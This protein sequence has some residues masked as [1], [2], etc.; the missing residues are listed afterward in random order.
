M[1]TNSRTAIVTSQHPE[2][3]THLSLN[4]RH[5][6]TVR[7]RFDFPCGK[8][9]P[10]SPPQK[11]SSK[12]LTFIS[13]YITKSIPPNAVEPHY[14]SFQENRRLLVF[15]EYSKS[16]CGT[17]QKKED[18]GFSILEIRILF[19]KCL[20]LNYYWYHSKSFLYISTHAILEQPRDNQVRVT[21]K[22][23]RTQST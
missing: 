9:S 12:D 8:F 16:P 13:T 17:P 5:P 10:D 19:G 4:L 7:D 23:R 22:E 18:N 14:G 6:S 15:N 1:A 3:G 11:K 2:L 20:Y 21:H